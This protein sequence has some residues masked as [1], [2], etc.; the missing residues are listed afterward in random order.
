L[1]TIIKIV[2]AAVILNATVRSA[3]AMWEY[4]QLK[5]AAQQIVL[6]GPQSTP[7]Q[8]RDQV[9]SKAEELGLPVEAQNITIR[10]ETSRTFAHV[11]YVQ[12]V[13]L[14][15]GYRQPIVFSFEVNALTMQG[16][17]AN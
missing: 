3:D 17:L 8:L 11:Y 15:P 16:T 10:R 6:F 7:G 9:F 2:I 5:D 12:P 4:Y 13:E 14:F 1:K